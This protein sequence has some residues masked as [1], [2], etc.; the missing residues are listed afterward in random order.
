[1]NSW[2]VACAAALC[3]AGAVR[4]QTTPSSA[5]EHAESLVQPGNAL[6]SSSAWK[7]SA[8]SAGS[9]VSIKASLEQ[10]GLEGMGSELIA[11]SAPVA[12]GKDTTRLGTL[13]GL[14]NATKVSY[15]HVW[16]AP[17][18]DQFMISSVSATIGHQKYSYYDGTTL[19]KQSSSKSSGSLAGQFG[20]VPSRSRNLMILGR[21]E[22]QSGHEESPTTTLCPLAAT[23]PV[24]CVTGPIG[25]PVH[26]ISR[27]VAVEVRVLGDHF[28][29][30]PRVSY[31]TASR[32]KGLYV[33]IYLMGPGGNAPAALNAGIDIHWTSDSK[34]S[35]GVFVGA[36]F[37][38]YQ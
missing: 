10:M 34:G 1:M 19:A 30:A 12:K 4:A 22:F 20:L 37:R 16:N 35:V 17:L 7:L 38:F 14:A 5:R 31:D 15:S 32:V 3:C 18:G 23:G 24:A 33:P 26:T 6:S 9:E 8:G 25:A 27:I 2:K 21:A 36:P 28:A 29:S 13:D 11:I